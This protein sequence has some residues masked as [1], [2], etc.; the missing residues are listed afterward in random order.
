VELTRAQ[1]AQVKEF[2]VRAFPHVFGLA[3]LGLI[4]AG[5]WALWGWPWAS[6]ATGIPPASFYVW[7]ELRSARGPSAG[8]MD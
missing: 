5:I 4:V 8:G 3:S 1:V 6:I 7:G 2:A